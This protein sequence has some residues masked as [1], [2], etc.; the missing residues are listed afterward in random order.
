[1]Y[2]M[3][4]RHLVMVVLFA[5]PETI[6]PDAKQW[7]RTGGGAIQRNCCINIPA[8]HDVVVNGRPKFREKGCAVVVWVLDKNPWV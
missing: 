8:K 1:M 5:L 7:R 6:R 4:A 3:Q 2:V